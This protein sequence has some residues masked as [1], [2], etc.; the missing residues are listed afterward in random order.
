MR[1]I[2]LIFNCVLIL[3]LI[4]AG[5]SEKDKAT[6]SESPSP[7]VP[8]CEHSV[9]GRIDVHTPTSEV[10]DWD[11]PVR[12]NDSVNTDC[13]Q[14]AIEISRDGTQLYVMY[15]EDVL[16]N[17]TPEQMLSQPD[18]TYRLTRYGDETE[19]G[20][21]Q[22]I[23]LGKGVDQSL[24]GELSFAPDGQK[25]YFHSLRITNLGYQINT[26]TD[27]YLDIY[28]AD[29]IDGVPG[30]GVNLGEPVNSIYPDG[31]HAIHPDGITLYFASDR[32][33]NYGNTDIWKSTF[34]GSN[35]SQPKNLGSTI[36]SFANDYQP[37][38]TVDG[39]TMYF[40]SGRNLAIGMAIYRS[41]DTGKGWNTPE[42]V[43][44]GL[45][46]EPSLTADGQLLYFV[47]VLSDNDGHYDTDVWV[48]K[49]I[50]H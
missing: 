22:F 1:G 9:A 3:A 32:S 11:T 38:F 33:P 18:N 2:N 42:L 46:G 49:R 14:D 48:S 17:I 50:T 34:D 31:E 37:A 36:N 6:E 24:D 44:S 10:A 13:P 20:N 27:D 21:R 15:L 35:W 4:F 41:Y 12:L 5:C 30:A 28:V 29:F 23:D 39:D 8:I 25:V 26:P 7:V 45:V 19:F 16:E 43:I 40:A 47:H